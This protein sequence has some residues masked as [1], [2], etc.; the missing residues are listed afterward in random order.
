VVFQFLRY[1]LYHIHREFYKLNPSLY[2]SPSVS[3]ESFFS[4]KCPPRG[5]LSWFPLF[6]LG[7]HFKEKIDS[8]ET[9]GE[10]KENDFI[11]KIPSECGAKYIGETERLLDIRVSEHRRNWLKL[12]REREK[13]GDEAA[14][15]SLL[16]SHAVEYN[17]QENWEEVTILAKES[18]IRK[19]KIHEA[20]VMHIEDNVISQPSIDIPPLWHS[21]LR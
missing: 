2:L 20:S 5:K 11:Y 6:L 7:G 21:I 18:S 15:S 8:C 9:E 4:L 17:H 3:H 14:A 13:E 10:G 16:A 1:I 19:R 12:D